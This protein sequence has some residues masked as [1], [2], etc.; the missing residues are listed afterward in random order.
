[1]ETKKCKHCQTDI[2]KKAKKCPNCQSDLRSWFNRHPFLVILLA[3]IL[4]F[5]F[6]VGK[7]ANKVAENVGGVNEPV[8]T[9]PTPNKL[10]NIGSEGT[11]SVEG[12]DQVLLTRTEEA[13]KTFAKAALAKDTAG[14][15]EL[16]LGGDAFFVKSET[17]VLVIDRGSLGVR[18]VRILDGDFAG[19][20]GYLPMEYIKVR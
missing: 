6:S 7:S 4:L 13:Q 2:P 9:T 16:V 3:L 8:T 1:M 5:I 17:K 11:V 19:E 20:T 14:L 15:T 18:K 12:Q 10:P